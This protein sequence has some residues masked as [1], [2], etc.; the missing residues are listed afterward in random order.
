MKALKF[1]Q[2]SLQAS[3]NCREAVRWSKMQLRLQM[4]QDKPQDAPRYAKMQSRSTPDVPKILSLEASRKLL[5][6][7]KGQEAFLKAPTRQKVPEWVSADFQIKGA[8]L[9]ISTASAGEKNVTVERNLCQQYNHKHKNSPGLQA[10]RRVRPG[11]PWERK[12][13]GKLNSL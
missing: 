12:E 6:A 11:P 4:S 1:R 5:W 9:R 3:K 7:A 8:E 10:Q 2:D 13:R